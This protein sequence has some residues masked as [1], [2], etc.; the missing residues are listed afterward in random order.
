MPFNMVLETAVALG[1]PVVRVFAGDSGSK[2]AREHV[3]RKVTTETQRI[4]EQAKPLGIS[5]AFEYQANTLNDTGDS[6]RQLIEGIGRDNVSTFWQTDAR[7]LRDEQ[8]EGLEEVLDYVSNVHV[9]HWAKGRRLALTE[10]ENDWRHYLGK[11]NRTK[12]D[13]IANFERDAA[14]LRLIVESLPHRKD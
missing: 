6:S 10:G 4:A 5:I 2:V 11:L 1:A 9:F 3:W 13:H 7:L 12:R 8:L 14:T